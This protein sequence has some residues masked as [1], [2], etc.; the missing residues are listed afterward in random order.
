MA[1][2]KYAAEVE[3]DLQDGR[4][5]GVN[6][7]PSFFINGQPLSGAAAYENFQELIDAALENAQRAQN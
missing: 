7:T 5:V 2:E 4:Q 1:S 3:K 6:S